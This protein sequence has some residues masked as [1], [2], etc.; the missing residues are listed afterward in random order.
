MKSNKD[1]PGTQDTLGSHAG[2]SQLPDIGA[3]L[4]DSQSLLNADIQSIDY[5]YPT[6]SS[7]ELNP[8]H[9][10]SQFI[11]SQPGLD[12]SFPNVHYPDG[13]D[14]GSVPAALAS[15]PTLFDGIPPGI[16]FGSLFL[17]HMA[18]IQGLENGDAAATAGSAGGGMVAAAPVDVSATVKPTHPSLLKPEHRNSKA[19]KRGPMDEMRQLVRILVKLVPKSIKFLAISEEGGSGNRVSEEQIKEYM[20]NTLGTAAPHP[21]WGLPLGWG[22]YLSGGYRRTSAHMSEIVLLQVL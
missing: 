4:P 13:H 15:V 19:V 20:K 3:Q 16:D 6:F 22:Q 14:A 10:A 5:A 7:Q 11:S 17:P 9:N 18:R 21:E 12:C 8:C 2:L 1:A